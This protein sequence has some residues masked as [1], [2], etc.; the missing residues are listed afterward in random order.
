MTSH[1]LVMASMILVS[2]CRTASCEDWPGWMGS[3]RSGIWR[4]S[5]IVDRIPNQGLP[6]LWRAE[7]GEGYSGPAIS[8]GRVFVTDYLADEAQLNNNPSQRDSRNGSERILC[9]ELSSG[10][11][12]WQF[13]YPRSYHLSYAA[14][15]RATP[16][17][18]GSHVYSLG[19]EGDLIC[20]Q[21]NDG[22]VVWRKQ[23]AEEY[24]TPSPLW[25]HSA[26]PLVHGELIYCLA[27]GTNSVVVALDKR[28]GAQVWGA[29]SATEIGYC[30]PTIA[31]IAG[32]QQLIVW[33]SEAIC[34]LDLTTGQTLWTYPLAP[35]YGMSI[36]APR[37][38]DNRMFACGIGD[39]AALVE[40]DASGQPTKTL[41]TGKPKFA[42]YG[43]NATPLWLDQAIYGSDCQLGAF[44]AVD[45]ETGQRLWESF[46]LTTGTDRRASH[47]TAF[48]VQ[49]DWRSFL[50]A[51]TGHLILARLSRVGFEELGRMQVL[52]P[53]G[54]CF[55]R[56]V[57]WSHPAFAERCV[58]ARN[59]KQIVCVSL[60]AEHQES[61]LK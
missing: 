24:K 54:E 43:S 21:C 12:L 23:L 4:E 59:D 8:K 17:V 51:E 50:F 16:T 14:G 49:N 27:G 20:L 33:H 34:G 22:K 25:G 45:P 5:G 47:G 29:L 10:K 32:R 41:W 57:V 42:V 19:A 6:V 46:A 13:S 30:P 18:D 36:C 28:T 2:L 53:T 58:V 55:G 39:T 37:F 60:A 56:P 48:M 38:R 35:K 11:Q 61:G 3:D 7:L 1:N 31:S 40:F 44:V 52:E 26:H 15:P 9:L